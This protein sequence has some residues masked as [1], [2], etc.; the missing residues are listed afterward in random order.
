MRNERECRHSVSY[1]AL[2]CPP[3]IC[4]CICWRHMFHRTCNDAMK[5]LYGKSLLC[6][7]D[8]S[9]YT[10]FAWLFLCLFFLPCFHFWFIVFFFFFFC[11]AANTPQKHLLFI[12]SV[13]LSRDVTPQ[14]SCCLKRNVILRKLGYF[15]YLWLINNFCFF[16]FLPNIILTMA[17]EL[18][19]YCIFEQRK[20]KEPVQRKCITW[21]CSVSLSPTLMWL[22]RCIS[23]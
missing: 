4:N 13:D 1:F 3:H 5:R 10:F 6:E 7:N 15:S 17:T 19:I 8:T 23:N 2:N 22:V 12:W 20:K 16:F 18:M 11:P 14:I 9:C 21:K